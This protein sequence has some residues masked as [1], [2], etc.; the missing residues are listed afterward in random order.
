MQY[1]TAT[2]GEMDQ[3]LIAAKT[4][5]QRSKLVWKVI[6]KT[7]YIGFATVVKGLR[8]QGA[9]MP[10]STPCTLDPEVA[11]RNPE[12]LLYRPDWEAL[13]VFRSTIDVCANSDCRAD[14]RADQSKGV[15]KLK[16]CAGC[17]VARYCSPQCQVW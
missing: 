7:D 3:A 8:A 16:Q 12:A 17:K 5:I 10:D 13:Q 15:K 1:T 2:L 4:S 6:F 14:Q 9:G 11:A